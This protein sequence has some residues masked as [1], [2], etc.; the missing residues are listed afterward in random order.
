MIDIKKELIDVSRL[1]IGMYI[2]DL[3]RPWEGAP[4]LMQGFLLEDEADLEKLIS[5][6]QH[7][8]V[9]RT[10]SVASHFVAPKKIDIKIKREGAVIRVKNPLTITSIGDNA[11]L[12]NGADNTK[13]APLLN[14]KS[15]FFDI[16][17]ELRNYQAPQNEVLNSQEGVIYNMQYSGNNAAAAHT[18]YH[19]NPSIEQTSVAKQLA[20]DVGGFIGGLFK[21]REKLS[22]VISKNSDMHKAEVAG[23]DGYRITIYEEE[24]PV[25]HEIATILPVYEQSQIATRAIFDTVANDHDL[26]L[27]AVS[28]VLDS[29]VDSIG[30][31]PDALLWL[32][33][34]KQTDNY[35][36]NHALNVSITLMAFANF[37]ALSKNQIKDIGLAGLLQDLGKVKLSADILLKEGKLTRE[38]FEHAQKHVEE[39]LKILEN[40]PNIPTTVIFLVAQH[41]ER[42]DGSGYPYQ[43]RGSQIGIP[44]QIAG[45]IDTYCALTSHKSYAKGVFH[46]QALDEI[47]RLAGHQF[48]SELIDQLVQF[49]GMYPVSSLV[50]LN[51]GE[52]GVVVQQNQV[53]RMLPRLLLLLDP[54][55]VRYHAPVILNLLNSPVAATGEIYKIIKSLA[56]D[57]YGLN[58]ND[59]YA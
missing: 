46:Q 24:L 57:S 42:I 21:K 56:P 1:S 12:K 5:L 40:T 32:A 29:M 48:S 10:R 51:T 18:N 8:Y 50:E 2:S 26:D 45:L 36:Y 28:E 49:M 13:G 41:H 25:E 15:S 16:L 9:D 35:A 30:R 58:P 11:G 38:E 52:V 39:G 53:R 37:L 14:E 20:S 27:T 19:L 6:C 4:F 34:L 33:K 59:F 7:V 55:K 17:R 54:N 43:L 47:H 44:S 22:T 23:D 3:D 31:S